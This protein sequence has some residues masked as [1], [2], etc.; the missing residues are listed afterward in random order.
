MGCGRGCHLTAAVGFS[1]WDRL[2]VTLAKKHQLGLRTVAWLLC[3]GVLSLSLFLQTTP[4]C[5]WGAW[6]KALLGKALPSS[7]NSSRTA[8]EIPDDAEET[9][10]KKVDCPRYE[11]RR[12]AG[13][14]PTVAAVRNK[15]S[16]LVYGATYSSSPLLQ[17]PVRAGSGCT[18][19]I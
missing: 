4:L 9:T 12:H 11:R 14:P 19:R 5:G 1:P 18:L 6:P 8:E 17:S 7:N 13:P 10:S 16:S 3:A 2:T 15:H